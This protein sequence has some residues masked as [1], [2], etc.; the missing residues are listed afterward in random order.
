MNVSSVPHTQQEFGPQL[1]PSLLKAS[2]KYE[3]LS[4]LLHIAP[5]LESAQLALEP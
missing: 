3:R 4:I 5:Q 1:S 2:E